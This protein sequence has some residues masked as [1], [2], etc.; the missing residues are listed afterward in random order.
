VVINE[1]LQ[2]LPSVRSIHIIDDLETDA[3]KAAKQQQQNHCIHTTWS[4]GSRIDNTCTHA[5]PVFQLVF[6]SNNSEKTLRRECL[7]FRADE[8]PAIDI[9][10]NPGW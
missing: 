9:L 7:D 4:H 6:Y 10:A 1:K 5:L 8:L 2:T 3:K